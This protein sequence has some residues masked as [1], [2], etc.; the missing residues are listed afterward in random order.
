MTSGKLQGARAKVAGQALYTE[1]LELPGM[2]VGKILRSHLPHARV[3]HID[4]ARAERRSGIL[5]VVTGEDVKRLHHPYLGASARG[6]PVLVMDRVR[7]CGEPVAAVAA[8][9]EE[10]AIRALERI[11]VEYEELPW[12]TDPVVALQE[13]APLIHDGVESNI[14]DDYSYGWGDV[15]R[16]FEESDLVLEDTFSF[17][18]VFQHPIEPIGGCLATVDGDNIVLYAPDQRPIASQWELA[19]IF[20]VD[21][22]SIIIRVPYIGGGFGSKYFKRE[23]AIAILLAQKAKRPTMI[24]STME[25]SFIMDCRHSYTYTLKTGFKKNGTIV[26]REL[27]ALVNVGAYG[28]SSV[29]VLRRSTQA[30]SAPYRIPHFRFAAKSVYTNTVP[31]GAFRSIGRP[32]V[33]WGCE[34]QIDE[35]AE[36]LGN[37]PLEIRMKNLMEQGEAFPAAEMPPL[38]ADVKGGLRKIVTALDKL[39]RPKSPSTI[40]KRGKGFACSVRPGGNESMNAAQAF[41]ELRRDGTVRAITAG[42]EMGQ[43]YEAMIRRVIATELGMAQDKIHV[44]PADTEIAPFFFGTSATRTT[45]AMGN[46]VWEAAK[47]LKREIL[48][49]AAKIWRAPSDRLEAREGMIIDVGV[50]GRSLSFVEAVAA[51][52]R[53][54]R[55]FGKGSYVSDRGVIAISWEPCFCGVEVEVD[56]ETGE[57]KVLTCITVAD[58]GHALNKPACQGQV[59]GGTVMALGHTFFEEMVYSDG[60]LANG[61]CLLYSVPRLMDLPQKQESF[62]IENGD[63]PGPYGSRGVGNSSMNPVAPAV[64]NAI[65]KAIGVRIKDLPIGSEKIL[66]ALSKQ[67][68]E[69]LKSCEGK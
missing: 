62:L 66:R 57:V 20:G 48:N 31:A 40:N 34:S 36:R 6:Q 4:V 50:E 3:K 22:R 45:Y 47:D 52:G 28:G 60:S 5:A 19:R 27:E 49:I 65:Y 11:E 8:S 35:A 63:G 42:T 37:S 30:A 15:A 9:D 25:E 69:L 18:S 12:V 51:L 53:G 14:C 68:N 17:P 59:D 2:V 1:D 61:N 26:A 10:S 58:V 46:A 16:G 23:A 44:E 67:G 56:P 29:H 43:G 33:I 38:D 32:Q 24:S 54:A 41:V 21:Q 7:F 55:I 13:G 64:G 39:A